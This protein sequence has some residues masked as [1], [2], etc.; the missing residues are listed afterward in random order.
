MS[1]VIILFTIFAITILIAS[2]KI[3][4]QY[5][6]G[7]VL[8]FGRFKSVVD[9]GLNFIL[10]HIEEL[11]K[12]DMREKMINVIPQKVITK[13]NVMVLVDA[14]IYCKVVDPVKAEFEVKDFDGAATVLAQTNL[15][16]LIGDKTLD[17]TFVSRDAI[18]DDLRSALDSATDNWGVKV[19]RVE[20][21]KFDPPAE[22]IE[23]MN[24]QMK[25]ERER[26]ATM[27]QAE[28]IKQSQILRAEGERN[29]E[30]LKAEGDAQAKVLRAEAEGKSIA[31][32]SDAANNYFNEKAQIWK[33]FEVSQNVLSEATKYVIPTSA[34]LVS[35]LNLEGSNN[36]ILPLKKNQS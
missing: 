31:I 25:A 23:A 20:I 13:D 16:N 17:E 5:E 32:V 12:I 11:V 9:P 7:I 18:N 29:A 4:N 19:T 3:I 2:V 34:D 1:F 8:R 14:V 30:I 24:L 22:I 36:N 26:R 35:V 21:Q 33:R 27:I 10:P 6:K 15:R 28:G